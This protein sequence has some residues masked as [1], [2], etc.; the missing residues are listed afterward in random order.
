[1]IYNL[2]IINTVYICYRFLQL[3]V[4]QVFINQLIGGLH[5]KI[6]MGEIEVA[7]RSAT[8]LLS[9]HRGRVSTSSTSPT[10]RPPLRTVGRLRGPRCRRWDVPRRTARCRAPRKCVSETCVLWVPGRPNQM[11]M[12]LQLNDEPILYILT[13]VIHLHTDTYPIYVYIIMQKLDGPCRF[14]YVSKDEGFS[15]AAERG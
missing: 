4:I 9:W 15:Q 3:Q 7:T 6:P 5:R 1:M 12:I 2:Q 10:P 8:M 11:K 14:G 13:V